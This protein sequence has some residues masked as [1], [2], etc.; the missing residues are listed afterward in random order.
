MNADLL[1]PSAG[2]GFRDEGPLNG[3]SSRVYIRIDR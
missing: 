1:L 3:V 2:T